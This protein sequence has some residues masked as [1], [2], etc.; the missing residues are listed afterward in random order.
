MQLEKCIATLDIL[1]SLAEVIP[2]LGTPLRGGSEAL[3]KILKYAQVHRLYYHSC[4]V[5]IIPKDVKTQK[6]KVLEIAE[7]AA[8]WCGTMTNVLQNA[9]ADRGELERLRDYVQDLVRYV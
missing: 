5:L 8:R 7:L 3:S 6:V 2:V 1:A 4:R 9:Q